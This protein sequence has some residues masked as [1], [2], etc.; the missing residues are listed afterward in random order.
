MVKKDGQKSCRIVIIFLL[1]HICLH[2]CLFLTTPNCAKQLVFVIIMDRQLKE[3][4]WWSYV[5]YLVSNVHAFIIRRCVCVMIF[6]SLFSDI[7]CRVYLST[8]SLSWTAWQENLWWWNWSGVWSI[9]ATW[10]L[11]MDTWTCRWELFLLFPVNLLTI[12][13]GWCVPWTERIL[14]ATIFTIS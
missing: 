7:T 2:T 3:S 5:S 8:Q 1:L 10:C 12:N 11:W 6:Q 4:S 13:C 14:F 9:K